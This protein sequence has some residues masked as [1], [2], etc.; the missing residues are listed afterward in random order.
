MIHWL[1]LA[2]MRVFKTVTDLIA[3][4][5]RSLTDELLKENLEEHTP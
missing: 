1:A 2:K 4:P 5:T 3:N